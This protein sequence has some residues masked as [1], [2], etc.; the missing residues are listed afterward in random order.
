MVGQGV[1]HTL[2]VLCS[3]SAVV[4]TKCPARL[5]GGGGGGGG[6]KQIMRQMGLVAVTI[7]HRINS[8][9]RSHMY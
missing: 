9:P 7:S 2:L 4:H 3:R 8:L 5:V 6:K 1:D